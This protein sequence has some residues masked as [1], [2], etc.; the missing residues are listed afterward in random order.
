MWH[1]STHALISVAW[2]APDYPYTVAELLEYE[3]FLLEELNFD[4]YIFHPYRPLVT[5]VFFPFT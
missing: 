5:Y 4:L 2:A 1:W 3:Y